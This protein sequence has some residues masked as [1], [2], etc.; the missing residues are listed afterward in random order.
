MKLL[1]ANANTTQAVTEACITEARRCASPDTEILGV[2]ASFGAS[3]VTTQ[4]ENV[5]AAHAALDLLARHYHGCDAAILAI[6]FDSGLFAARGLLPIPVLGMTEA[7]LHSACM[8]GARFGMITFG[9][10]ST[11]LYRE[12][13]STLGLNERLAALRTID[14]A[15]VAAYLAPDAQNEA[16][17]A[18]AEALHCEDGADIVVIC[19]A[20]LAGVSHRLQPRTP[21]P[22][23]DGIGCAVR[24]AEAL[25]RITP[26]N[27]TGRP[28]LARGAT[29]TGLSP[30]LVAL[31]RR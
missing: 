30:E 27:T 5:I 1:L 19:G 15:S 2:T 7:A 10:A 6:S 26:A 24:Q 17:L 4:P 14:V 16:I 29:L 23:L 11:P 12:L 9:T 13:V 22:L 18:A 25:V 21:V 3:I 28:A 20:A 8:L 31:L